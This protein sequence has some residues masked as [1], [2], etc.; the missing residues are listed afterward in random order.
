V[1]HASSSSFAK[2]FAHSVFERAQVIAVVAAAI[3]VGGGHG[4]SGYEVVLDLV[5]IF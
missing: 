1:G 3:V 4:A 5:V 2:H